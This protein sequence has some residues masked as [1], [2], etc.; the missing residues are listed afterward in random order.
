MM[1][2]PTLAAIACCALV[3]CEQGG[4]PQANEKLAAV[5]AL[6]QVT[7]SG[8][9][10]GGYMASQ[11][12]LANSA[13][14]TG[15][16]VIA[17]GPWGCA[18]GDIGTALAGCIS[19]E[20]IDVTALQSTAAAM[21][22]DGRID[23][24]DNIAS[25]R[26]FFFLG[27]ADPVIKPAVVD[28]ARQFM[29]AYV[30]DDQAMFVGDVGATHGWVTSA[31]GGECAVFGAPYINQCGYD[32]AG[33]VLTQ[34]YG[35]LN[36]RAST[37]SDL[38]RFKQDEFG[39]ASLAEFGYAY[40]PKS[41]NETSCRVHVFFHGCEQSAATVGTTLATNSGFNEW[42]ESNNLIVLYPQVEPSSVAPMNPLG[43]WDWWGYTGP[44]YLDRDA[45]QLA[46]V[47]AM[48]GRLR[49]PR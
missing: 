1:K 37:T 21:A 29:S 47:R 43:C 28:A 45:P 11:F 10:S 38:T 33:S 30:N 24:L 46:A 26:L 2:N 48:L 20:D 18:G 6:P 49:Q 12:Q 31:Y 25:H 19:G 4:T 41:C 8:L 27:A 36:P 16:A 17:A 3:A 23:A 9:S 15:A 14:V 34:M 22:D 39:D 35:A 13:N 7:V 40:I 5:N 32:L 44:N 42:A